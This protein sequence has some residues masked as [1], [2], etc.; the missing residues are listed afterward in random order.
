[1]LDIERRK[2]ITLLGGAGAWPLVAKAQQIERVYRIGFLANDPKIQNT[3]FGLAFVDGLREGGFIEGKNIL[4]DWRFAEGRPE[5]YDQHANALV[6]LRMDL[7]VTSVAPA[8]KA[9]KKATSSIPIVML[10]VSDPVAQAIVSSLAAPGGNITGLVLHESPEMAAKRFR[11]F[12]EWDSS[13]SRL[14]HMRSK[15]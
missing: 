3:T 6:R 8:T 2:F 15:K 10:N 13:C 9:A 12:P 4:V 14:S 7:I 1:M 5:L 11:R